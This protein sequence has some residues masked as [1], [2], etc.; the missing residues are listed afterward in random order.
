MYSIAGILKPIVRYHI[1]T[2]ISLSFCTE[3]GQFRTETLYRKHRT[4]ENILFPMYMQTTKVIK[5][6]IDNFREEFS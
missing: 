6:Y 1:Y 4:E 3:T 2:I 5:I